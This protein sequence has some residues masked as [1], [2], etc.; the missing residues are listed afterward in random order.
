MTRPTRKLL[1]VFAVFV[2][3]VAFV[4]GKLPSRVDGTGTLAGCAIDRN[5][6]VIDLDAG[7]ERYLPVARWPSGLG[8]DLA[9]RQLLDASG[10]V[11]AKAGDRVVVKGSIVDV[12][13]DPSPCYFTR[14]IEI[15]SIAAG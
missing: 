11:I 15:E 4:I 9:T 5:W 14:G 8:Y 10:R 12:H 13:G 7:Q 2:A 3:L 6:P 1:V